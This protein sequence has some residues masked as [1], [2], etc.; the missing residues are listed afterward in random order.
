MSGGEWCR[1][2]W[3]DVWVI[4]EQDADDH[5]RKRL[6]SK[7]CKELAKGRDS[8]VAKVF[9]NSPSWTFVAVENG[10]HS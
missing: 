3:M 8:V 4:L 7:T 9:E 2:E 1:V 10:Q 5:A 6:M